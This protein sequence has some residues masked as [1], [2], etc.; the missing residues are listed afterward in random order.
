ML[1]WSIDL[2][3]HPGKV[4][5]RCMLTQR[6]VLTQDMYILTLNVYLKVKWNQ[7]LSFVLIKVTLLFVI[8]I[9]A[10]NPQEQSSVFDIRSYGSDIIHTLSE[11]TSQG[12]V[13]G[14]PHFSFFSYL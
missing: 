13:S 9:Y 10:I 2:F 6:W 7:H 8:F 5:C 11:K 3:V 12:I 4:A 14:N 1:V